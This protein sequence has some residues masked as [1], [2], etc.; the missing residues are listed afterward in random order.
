LVLEDHLSGFCL[1]IHE[2]NNVK[3][4]P[5]EPSKSGI[6]DYQKYITKH[7]GSR[8]PKS[9]WA[10]LDDLIP[11]RN[12]VVHN[13]G[14][15]TRSRHQ[16]DLN[17]IALKNIGVH[18]SAKIEKTDMTPLYLNDNMLMIEPKYCRST[19]AN[20]TK[21]ISTLCT[22]ANLPMEITFT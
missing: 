19:L 17:K 12:C 7:I 10:W 13:S 1:A 18:I 5:P 21:L 4:T 14:N 15:V 8:I 2:L 3:E 9:K 16:N 6:R 11:V 22:K 20:I